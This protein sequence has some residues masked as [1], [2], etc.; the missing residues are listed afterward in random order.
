MWQAALL[1]ATRRLGEGNL[2]D[3]AELLAG[4]NESGNNLRNIEATYD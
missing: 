1:E 2:S 3:L 4:S